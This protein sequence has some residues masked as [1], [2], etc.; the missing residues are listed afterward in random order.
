MWLN[1]NMHRQKSNNK[2]SIATDLLEAL[3]REFSAAIYGKDADLI[4]KS[5]VNGGAL[6]KEI[7]INRYYEKITSKTFSRNDSK[8]KI[9]N[10]IRNCHGINIEIFTPREALESIVRD[11]ICEYRDPSLECIDE[12]AFEIENIVE[13]CSK[14]MSRFPNLR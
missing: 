14:R 7:I 8:K 6:I 12:V 10:A 3:Q 1:I 5:Q 4:A 9:K 11:Q 2:E 13:E